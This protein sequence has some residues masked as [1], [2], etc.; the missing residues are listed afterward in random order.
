LCGSCTCP[1]IKPFVK[2]EPD[3]TDA[4]LPDPIEEPQPVPVVHHSINLG[5][6]QREASDKIL[7]WY[8]NSEEQI[9][10]LA[11]YAGTGKTTLAKYLAAELGNQ[12]QFGAY[13]GKAVNILREKGCVNVET[14][15]GL[16]YKPV[17]HDKS[18]LHELRTELKE[19]EGRGDNFKATSLRTE[20]DV[21]VKEHRK[22]KFDLNMDVGGG[23]LLFVDEYSMLPN[24]VLADLRRK[25]K[26]ILFMGDPFQLPPVKGN[27]NLE[28]DFFLTEIHRQALESAIVR[29]SKDIRENQSFGYGDYGDLVYMPLANATADMLM[30]VDQ[31][32][33]G[34]NATRTSLNHWYRAQ[35]G[36]TNPLPVRGD[37]MICLKNNKKLNLFNGMICSATEDAIKAQPHYNN[38]MLK[39]DIELPAGESV[40]QVWDGDIMGKGEDYDWD[41]WSMKSL[42]RF[43]YANAITCHKSQGS[44]FKTCAIYNEPVGNDDLMKRRWLYTAITRSKERC[45]LLQP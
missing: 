1:G 19:A 22:P 20:I 5:D 45:F 27:C 10:T 14:I 8:K 32:I 23:N 21:M 37:K 3:P 7:D 43:D 30:G 38:F 39:T 41:D 9:F 28:P 35:K 36:I 26:K 15:H 6:Q 4:L 42:N 11:G 13:T 2:T 17:G 29:L 40:I 25:F 44:E 18:K 16:L 34:R 24:E 33:C 31:I 12:V